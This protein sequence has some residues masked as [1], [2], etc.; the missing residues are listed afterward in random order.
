MAEG[1]TVVEGSKGAGV[2]EDSKESVLMLQDS[3]QSGGPVLKDSKESVLMLGDSKQSGGPVHEDSKESVPM[4]EDS[5]QS[6]GPAVEDSKKE[7]PESRAPVGD[8]GSTTA[9][10]TEAA[11]SHSCC[12]GS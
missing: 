8:V 10:A 11:Q 6:G 1:S 4:L 5:K 2:V 7:S 3:K 12:L 9:E